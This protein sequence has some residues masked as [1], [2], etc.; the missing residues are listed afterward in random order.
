M[1]QNIC[2]RTLG[3]PTVAITKLLLILQR[4][5]LGYARIV[6]CAHAKARIRTSVSKWGMLVGCKKLDC[7]RLNLSGHGLTAHN[8]TRASRH[9]RIA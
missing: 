7:R 3:G 5:S 6:G 4:N 9:L 2:S 8:V 1:Q